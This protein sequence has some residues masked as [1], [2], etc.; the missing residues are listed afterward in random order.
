MKKLFYVCRTIM[1]P[2]AAFLVPCKVMDKQKFKMTE[3]GHV[4]VSNHLSWMDIPYQMFWLPG[5]KR[6]LSKKENAGGKFKRWFLWNMGV[7]FIDR[8]KPELSVMRTCIKS[9]KDDGEIMM[10]YPEGTRNKVDRRIQEMHSG[11]AMFALKGDAM[12]TPVVIHHKGK[13]FKRNYIGVGDTVNLD[14]LRGRKLDEAILTEATSRFRTAMEKTLAKLDWWVET[15]GWKADKKFARHEKKTLK[16]QY[17]IA[18]KQAKRAE[19][20]NA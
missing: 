6:M 15:K 14:D 3:C 13:T 10:V 11:A 2:I 4:T 7:I 16:K 19:R 18:K 17:A 1:Y 12:V 20:N 8:E 9:L 5:Y